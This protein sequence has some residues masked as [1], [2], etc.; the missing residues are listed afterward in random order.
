[1]SKSKLAPVNKESKSILQLELPA[2]LITS[3]VK[4]KITKGFKIPIKET[5]M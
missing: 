2:A 1:M 3:R 5:F 4:Q